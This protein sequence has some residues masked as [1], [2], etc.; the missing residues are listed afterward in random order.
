MIVPYLGSSIMVIEGVGAGDGKVFGI[1]TMVG[2]VGVTYITVLGSC[3]GGGV[4][5][6]VVL[7]V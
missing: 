5:K 6:L 1:S 2:V 4:G 3:T 7:A